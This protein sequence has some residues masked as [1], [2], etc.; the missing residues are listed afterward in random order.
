[1]KFRGII[2]GANLYCDQMAVSVRTRKQLNAAACAEVGSAAFGTGFVDLRISL[3][4][5]KVCILE[6][7]S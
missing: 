6:Q 2:E 4:Q 5:F 1:M 7:P 3:Q